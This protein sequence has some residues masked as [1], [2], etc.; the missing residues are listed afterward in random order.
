MG[1]FRV[2]IE[3][4]DARGQRFQRVDALVDSGATY[5]WLPTSLLRSLGLEP[6]R[7]RAFELTDGRQVTYG[8]AWATVRLDGIAQPTLVVFG[9]DGT[10]PLLGIVTLEEF[11]LGIDV[12]NGR[13]IP[14][15][16]LLKRAE[17]CVAEVGTDLRSVRPLRKPSARR[18]TWINKW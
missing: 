11:G 5:T 15:P 3:I 16:G 8:I 18:Q 1:E 14:T 12:V 2:T 10:E 7:Q 13:L 4:G 9:E 17:G 6:E